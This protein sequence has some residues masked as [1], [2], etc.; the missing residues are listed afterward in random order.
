MVS[1]DEPIAVVALFPELRRH[2]LDLLDA[3]SPEQW[4]RPTVCP[5]WSVKDVALHLLGGD[6]GNLARRRDGLTDGIAPYVP[7]GAD[8]ADPGALVA[9][10]NAWNEDWVVAA[11]RMSPRVLRDL[12]AVTGE[13]LYA[14]YR[15][16]DLTAIGGP[17]TWAGPEPAPVWL[18]IAR[19]YTEQWMH[20][21]QM[22]DAAGVGGIRV[23][24]L[25][26]PV[27]ATF[28]HALPHALRDMDAPDGARLRVV[29]TG[30]AGGAWDAVR[31]DG[32]WALHT[33]SAGEP[34]ATATLDAEDAWRLW[35]RGLTPEE[36]ARAVRTTGDAR[37]AGAVRA[38]VAFIG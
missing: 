32:R 18:D 4:A 26:A 5:G 1:S 3:L 19:E 17:V 33:A 6:I 7:P 35:T 13:P 24:R 37:L 11:R 21:A 23:R 30:E 28:M 27:I 38:M 22:R 14:Y 9:A 36:E 29:V 2:L 10:V 25:F 8:L 34:A 12:L 15:G 16:L 20:Q 31:A